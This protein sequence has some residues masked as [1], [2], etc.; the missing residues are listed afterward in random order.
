[1]GNIN[2]KITDGGRS[3]KLLEIQEISSNVSGI[4]LPSSGYD[5]FSKNSVEFQ[6]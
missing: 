2:E 1:L 6:F 4:F 3:M 5:F